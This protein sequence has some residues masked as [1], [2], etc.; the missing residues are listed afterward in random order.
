MKNYIV[1]IAAFFIVALVCY[2]VY[3]W[4]DL[5]SIFKVEISYL[6]WIA[7]EL[8]TNVLIVGPLNKKPKDKNDSKRSKV[9]SDLS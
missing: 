1:N 4:T 3:I 9:S 5:K 7:L 2:Y 8:I 6:Q